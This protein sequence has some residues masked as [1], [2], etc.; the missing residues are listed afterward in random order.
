MASSSASLAPFCLITLWTRPCACFARI[1]PRLP[2]KSRPNSADALRQIDDRGYLIPYEGG[3]KPVF[4]V[5]VAFS[6]KNRT[7]DEGWIIEEC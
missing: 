1:S 4:K 3:N 2:S 5:G 6:A 7:I